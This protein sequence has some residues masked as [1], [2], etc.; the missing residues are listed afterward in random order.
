M[1]LELIGELLKEPTLQ[2]KLQAFMSRVQLE[3]NLEPW[4]G[5]DE[6]SAV[7]LLRRFV[8]EYKFVDSES[9]K[10]LPLAKRMLLATAL[11]AL[12]SQLEKK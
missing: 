8:D 11:K 5:V 9:A 12:H 10:K 3:Y 1:D 2:P 6:P 4:R 7:E